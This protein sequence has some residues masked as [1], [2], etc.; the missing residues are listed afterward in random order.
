MDPQPS[1]RAISNLKKKK[2][3]I[4]F[5]LYYSTIVGAEASRITSVWRVKIKPQLHPIKS[6]ITIKPKL[7]I[8]KNKSGSKCKN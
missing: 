7:K 6:P 3:K 1:C 5:K 2:K 4:L 8:H